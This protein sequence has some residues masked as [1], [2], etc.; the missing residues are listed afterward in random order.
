MGIAVLRLIRG[1]IIPPAVSRPRLRGVTSSSTRESVFSDLPPRAISISIPEDIVAMRARSAEEAMGE[2][3]RVRA[4]FLEAFENGYDV[5]GFSNTV[6]YIL[7]KE[8][9]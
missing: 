3:L 7:A 8:T 2:R 4:Q 6:G 5:I 1:V 9:K